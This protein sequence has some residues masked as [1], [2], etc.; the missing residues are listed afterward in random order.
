MKTLVALLL[1]AADLRG[2]VRDQKD[3]TPLAGVSVYLLDTGESAISEADG[4]FTFAD[5][6][7]GTLRVAAIDPA[8]E[9][10]EITA[11]IT[12][13][14]AAVAPIVLELAGNLLQGNEVLVEVERNKP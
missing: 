8:Y 1:I 4:T 13:S 6:P 5:V 9:K 12:S 7:T 14:T 2:V 11:T 10:K 3:G